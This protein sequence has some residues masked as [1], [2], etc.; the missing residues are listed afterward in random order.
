MYWNVNDAWSSVLEILGVDAINNSVVFG[1]L[2]RKD[3]I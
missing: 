2:L 1:P 3:N